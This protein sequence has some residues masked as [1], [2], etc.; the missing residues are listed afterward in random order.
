MAKKSGWVKASGLLFLLGIIISVV[1]G[2]VYP[3][4]SGVIS[5][6]AIIGFIIGILGI[7]GVGSIDRADSQMFLLAV[8]A[9]T[10][11]ANLG[12]ATLPQPL[13]TY[14]VPMV[15][16]IKFLVLPAAILIALETIWRAGSTKF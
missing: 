2:L 14:L 6:L 1:A 15:D 4:N 5:I 8:V 10:A 9:L 7:A 12:F 16:Y 3:S 13:S 11:A